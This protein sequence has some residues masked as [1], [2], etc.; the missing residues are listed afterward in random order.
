MK[1]SFFF[2]VLLPLIAASSVVMAGGGSGSGADPSQAFEVSGPVVAVTGGSGSGMPMLTVDDPGLGLVDIGLGPIWFLQ[3]AG[4]S[5]EEGDSVHLLAYACPTCAAAAV[6]AWVDNLT[7][8]TSVD[9]RDEDGRPLWTQRQYNRN[10]SGRPGQGVGSGDNNGGGQTGGSGGEGGTG[11]PGG[12]GG[13]GGSGEPGGSGNGTG[14]GPGNGS[15]LDMSL[16]ETVTGEVVDFTGHAGAGQPILTLYVD[17]ESIEITLSPYQP[18]EAAGLVIVPA[19]VLTVTFAPTDCEEDPHNV[20]IS[21]I[22]DATGVL[23]QL[24][25]PETGF[26]MAGGGSGHNRPNWP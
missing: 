7:N 1:R 5:A 17:G 4:F 6:A 22:D 25:D 21:I 20:A 15:G 10:G 24:R 18:I 12:S 2:I 8:S 23:V 14:S 3:E 16:V 9:L 13:E 26:P 11:E 19:L